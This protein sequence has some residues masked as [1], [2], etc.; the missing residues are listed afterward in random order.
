VRI[1]FG[2]GYASLALVDCFVARDLAALPFASIASTREKGLQ[3]AVL[4]QTNSSEIRRSCDR[5]GAWS[6]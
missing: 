1:I 2:L 5:A 4:G 6:R 3:L